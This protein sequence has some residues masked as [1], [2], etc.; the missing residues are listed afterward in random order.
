MSTNGR[1]L[2]IAGAALA[3]VVATLAALAAT[4]PG[5]PPSPA[6]GGTVTPTPSVREVE[7]VKVGGVFAAIPDREIHDPRLFPY[8]F[9]SPTPPPTETPLDGTYLRT[10]TLREVGGA[11][12]GLPYRCLRC[13][14]FRVDA[15]VSTLIFARGAYYLHHHLSGFKTLGSYVVDGHR[16]TLFNDANCPQTPGVYRF[17]LTPHGLRL[18]AIE[19]DCPFSG[20]RALDLMVRPWTRVS[21]CVRRIDGLWPGEIAC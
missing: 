13:P 14:P 1:R 20:E 21:A 19:D 6:P 3:A 4:D 8:P 9:M 17:E 12:I 15:G 5:T 11:R 10:M 16:V 2:G 18:R 7:L